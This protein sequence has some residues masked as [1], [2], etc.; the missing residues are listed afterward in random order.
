MPC[1]K[2]QA[3]CKLNA[4]TLAK[5]AFQVMSEYKCVLLYYFHTTAGQELIYSF[6]YSMGESDGT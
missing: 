2:I 3:T 1:T 4:V 5:V 6:K